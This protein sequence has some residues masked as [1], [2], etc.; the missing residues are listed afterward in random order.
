[1]E[2][3]LEEMKVSDWEQLKE[4]YLEGISTG[5]ATFQTEVPS[6]E[7][8]DKGHL[9]ICRLVARSSDKVLGWAALSPISSRCCY[10]GV[11]E[12]SIYISQEHKGQGIGTAI[13]NELIKQSEKNGIW[14]LHS[15]I[16]RENAASLT[17]HK[18][19]GFREIG[20]REKIAKMGNGEWHDVVLMERRSKVIGID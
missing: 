6:W 18:K 9:N 16:I 15:G 5:L 19:C 12:V 20:I 14:T 2:Y 11:T 13:M 3:I 10:E 8:W 7:N 4:I 17:M 1:M